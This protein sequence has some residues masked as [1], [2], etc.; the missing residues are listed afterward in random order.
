MN[1]VNDLNLWVGKCIERNIFRR[2]CPTTAI[3]L[4]KIISSAVCNHRLCSHFDSVSLLDAI[5]LPRPIDSTK[6]GKIK[7]SKYTQIHRKNR[8]E[9]ISENESDCEKMSGRNQQSDTSRVVK[10]PLLSAVP[11]S[12]DDFV[13]NNILLP[14]AEIPPVVS[15][16]HLTEETNGKC[17]RSIYPLH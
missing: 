7:V 4:T 11:H 1:Y 17:I 10:N 6:Y 3:P 5:P 2:E 16:P 9:K 14:A 13:H 12:I 15:D 8:F